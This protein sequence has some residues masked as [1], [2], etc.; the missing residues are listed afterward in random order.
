MG[1]LYDIMWSGVAEFLAAVGECV[2]L[3]TTRQALTGSRLLRLALFSGCLLFPVGAATAGETQESDRQI[4]DRAKSDCADG[5]ES[6][7][8]KRSRA[9]EP[10]LV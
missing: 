4:I 6:R 1:R 7:C 8:G 3:M 10:I 9:R 5:R 2:G